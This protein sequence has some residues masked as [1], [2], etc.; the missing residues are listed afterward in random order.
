VVGR[1]ADHHAVDVR[2]LRLR[3]I[4]RL[5]AAVQHD[6]QPPKNPA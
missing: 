6:G 2:E 1:A 3:G 4:E 5:D